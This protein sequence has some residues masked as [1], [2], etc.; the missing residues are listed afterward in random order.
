MDPETVPPRS[1]PGRKGRY[2]SINVRT[3]KNE[4]PDLAVRAGMRALTIASSGSQFLTVLPSSSTAHSDLKTR[5]ITTSQ[6]G[7]RGLMET[8]MKEQ[9]SRMHRK[10][11]DKSHQCGDREG[12]MWVRGHAAQG[13]AVLKQNTGHSCVS[14]SVLWSRYREIPELAVWSA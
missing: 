10:P 6:G 9:V 12:A 4:S 11:V 3:N 5:G 13:S 14:L 2:L 7:S 8:T 1:D